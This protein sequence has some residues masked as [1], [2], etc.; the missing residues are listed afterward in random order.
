MLNPH[1]LSTLFAS[2]RPALARQILLRHRNYATTTPQRPYTFHIGASWAGKP[3][4]PVIKASKV[5][6]PSDTVIG[7]W[8]DKTL[9]RPKHVRSQD[10][11]EDFFFV[12]EVRAF[13]VPLPSPVPKPCTQT[14]NSSHYV[15]P[16]YVLLKRPTSD[17]ERLSRCF[18][19][20]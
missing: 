10:A 12:E 17:A 3:E 1:R 18:Y 11:G 4:D 9:S 6:F 20:L 19:A 14:R 16:F 5:P 8:R 13:S 7:A 2:Y 15:L